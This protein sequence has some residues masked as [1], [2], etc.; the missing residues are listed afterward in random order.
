MRDINMKRRLLIQAA[1]GA[2]LLGPLSPLGLNTALAQQ[3]SAPRRGGTLRVSV[4]QAPSVI[5]PLLLRVNPEYLVAELLYSALTRLGPHMEAQPDLATAWAASDDLKTWTFTLRHGVKFH[6]GTPMDSAD[7]VA[8]FTRILDPATAS[9]ARNNVGPIDSVQADG[10]DK[11]VFHLKQAYADMPVALAY[12]DAKIIPKAIAMGDLTR[13]NSEAVGTGPFKLVSYEPSR[14]VVVERNPDYYDPARP[15]LDRVVVVVNP[16]ETSRISSLLAGD[17][18]IVVNVSGSN[19]ARITNAPGVVGLRTPS[20]QFLNVIMRCDQPPFNDPRVRKALSLAVDRKALVDYVA[21]GFGTVGTDTPLNSAYHFYRHLPVPAIDPQAAR[22]LLADAGHPNGLKVKLVASSAPTTRET[23]AVAIR[24]MAR[25]AGFD[26]EVQTMPHATYLD[27][28][29]LKGGFYVGFY[30]M[31]PTADAIFSLL[32]TSTAAWNETKWNNAQFDSLISQA[33]STLDETK[34]ADLYGQAQTLMAQ[35]VPTV[36]PVF[37][38]LL[39]GRR[40]YVE[41]FV[42]NPRGAVFDLDRAWLSAAAPKR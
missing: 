41:N 27:Q 10:P 39:G 4:D 25:P 13:L 23:L 30:N 40:D 34:R 17:N 8:T 6:D 35:E 38:D 42:L 18:D 14:Q 19:Y 36:I 15:Y 7:V 33:R 20:G 2:G 24:E 37:F 9:P 28:V 21:D 26:I 22:K 16:D 12:T 5:H 3:Q 11:V 31:Q 32:Y 1:S 29:W